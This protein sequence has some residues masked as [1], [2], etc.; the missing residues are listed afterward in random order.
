MSALVVQELGG[1]LLEQPV[2]QASLLG[3]VYARAWLELVAED[4]AYTF[5][6]PMQ[7]HSGAARPYGPDATGIFWMAR[8]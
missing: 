1:V 7:R 2:V 5:T 8:K 6:T 4:H 3:P